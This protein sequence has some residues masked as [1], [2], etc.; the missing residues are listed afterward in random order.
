MLAGSESL[1]VRSA[2]DVAARIKCALSSKQNG[3]EDLLA[4]LIAEACIDVCPKNPVNFDVDNVRTIKIPGSALSASSV[5]KGMV[6][7]RDTEGSIKRKGNCKVAVY[8]QV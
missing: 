7:R 8:T 5:V 4:G 1:D 2:A 6:I 3:F